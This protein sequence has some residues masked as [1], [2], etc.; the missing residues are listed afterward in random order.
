MVR[1]EPPQCQPSQPSAQPEEQPRRRNLRRRIGVGVAIAAVLIAVVATAFWR[2]LSLEDLRDRREAFTA[3]VH[4]HPVL[5]VEVY[6]AAYFLV[7]GLSLP[8]ALIMSLSAGYLFGVVKGTAAAVTGASLGAVAMYGVARW[9]MGDA[10]RAR[11]AASGGLGSR[12]EA[13]VRR[14]AFLSLLSLRLIP[15]VPFGLVNVAAAAVR[16]PVVTYVG[17]TVAGIFPSTLIYVWIGHE[18]TSVLNRNGAPKMSKVIQP[19]VFI[20]LLGLFLLAATPLAWKAWRA[21]KARLAAAV[22]QA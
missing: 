9:L 19:E 15:G 20:P 1:A 13:G 7:V 5:S 4:A 11:L 6:M 21:R 12:L 10:L 2:G 3:Y 18:L 8:G 17:A 22:G 14:N 16:I